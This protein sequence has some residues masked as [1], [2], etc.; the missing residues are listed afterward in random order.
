MI[1]AAQAEGASG[2]RLAPYIDALIATGDLPAA[3]RRARAGSQRERHR[4]RS[5]PRPR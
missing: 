3:R 4:T 5:R 1:A 2:E